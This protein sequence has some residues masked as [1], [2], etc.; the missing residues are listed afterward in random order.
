MLSV[1]V[2]NKDSTTTPINPEKTEL[3]VIEQVVCV[4]A[5]QRDSMMKCVCSRRLCVGII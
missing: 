2:A 3:C 5:L 4:S 1:H